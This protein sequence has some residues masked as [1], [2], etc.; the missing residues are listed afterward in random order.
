VVTIFEPDVL[1]TLKKGDKNIDLS[2]D[3]GRK[4]IIE[5]KR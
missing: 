4:K 1:C 2:M 3:W 5:G